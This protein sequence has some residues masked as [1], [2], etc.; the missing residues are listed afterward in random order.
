MQRPSSLRQRFAEAA[1]M[2][3]VS[4][5]QIWLAHRLRTEAPDLADAVERGEMKL[6]AAIKVLEER[7][8]KAKAAEPRLFK[9]WRLASLEERRAFTAWLDSAADHG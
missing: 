9:A 4:E 8:G 5:R 6:P 3:G 2:M 7:Q 1:Q